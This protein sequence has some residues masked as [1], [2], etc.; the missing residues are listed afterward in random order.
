MCWVIAPLDPTY[1]PGSVREDVDLAAA[2]AGPGADQ[3]REA[4][5]APRRQLQQRR[6]PPAPDHGVGPALHP[7]ARRGERHR[8]QLRPVLVG[9]DHHRLVGRQGARHIV[10][11]SNHRDQQEHTR[12]EPEEALHR[13]VTLH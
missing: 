3:A 2:A 6:E 1:T 7:A 8:R 13:S 9:G 10:D 11:R 12:E 4:E 5:Q